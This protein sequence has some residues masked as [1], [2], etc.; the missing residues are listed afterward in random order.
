MAEVSNDG[1]YCEGDTI[2][3]IC[4]NPQSGATYSWSGPGGWTSTA[5]NPVIYPATAA[6]DGNTYSLVKTLNGVSS[7]PASTTIEVIPVNTS[8]NV[9]PA[10]ATIC[11]GSS[12]TLMGSR[13]S[14]Y[15]NTYSWSPGGLS[16]QQ[17]TV[18]PTTTTTYS[19]T[20]TV[21][22][23][24]TGHDTVTVNVRQPQHQSYTLDTC[25]SSYSWHGH[26]ANHE[27][28]FNWTWSHQDEYGCTQ[29]D[30]L[31]LTLS[32]SSF[33][34]PTDVHDSV[35]CYSNIQTPTPP[36]IEVCGNPVP[37]QL[38]STLNGINGGCGYFAYVYQY[39]VAGTPYTWTY[40]YHLN[41]SE[42]SVPSNRDTL[43]QCL[44]D[45]VAPMP[46]VVVNA[47]GDTIVPESPTVSNQTN[48]C[49]GYLSY[50]WLY[51]DCD[52]HRKT[53]T[54]TYVVADT[55][56]PVFIVPADTFVCRTLEGA[57]D[58]NPNITG[59]PWQ[60]MDNCSSLQ[61]MTIVCQDSLHSSIGRG[62]DTLLRTWVVADSCDNARTQT[63]RILIYPPDSAYTGNY[64]CEGE[65]FDAYG[66]NFVA[67]HD[68]VVY[69]HLQSVHTGCDSVTE[70]FLTVWHP[71]PV[72]E[73]VE[74]CD[75]YTWH[76]SIYTT[77][78]IKT[79][80]H[81]DAN[82][83]KQVDT[84]HLTIRHN[85]HSTL[86]SAICAVDFPFQWNGATFHIPGGMDSITIPN[87]MG[88]D[89]LITM[90]VTMKPNT[91]SVLYDT[92]VQNALPYDTLN[93][94]FAAAGSMQTTISNV[95]G[96][97][98]VVTMI[99]TVLP[100]ILIDLDSTVCE[101]DLP[102]QWNGLD[103][104]QEGTQN[105]TLIASSTVDST[106]SMHLHVNPNT[107]ST[108]LDT[109]IENNLSHTFNGVVFA[110]SVT[111][112]RVVI[113][114]ANGCDSIITY[115]LFVW[116]NVK[117]TAD[118]W[119]C[120]NNNWPLEWNG[121]SF[122]GEG[123]ASVVLT[124]V[125]GEDS[126]LLMRVHVNPT[127]TT[128]LQQEI[129][130][131]DLPYRYING[132]IDT[133]FEVG[134]PPLVI[135]PYILSTGNG[136]D[137]VVTLRLDVTDTALSIVSTDDFCVDDRA[138]LTVRSD[139]PDYEWSTGETTPSIVVSEPGIYSVTASRGGCQGRAFVRIRPCSL[140]LR[141]PNAITPG[142]R[143]GLNDCF[144]LPEAMLDQI[145]ECEI[146]IFNRWGNVVFHSNDKRFKWYGDYQ[147]RVLKDEVLVFTM[148]YIDDSRI[149]H[150]FKGSVVVL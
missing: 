98:S 95:Y 75:S 15:T 49:T 59:T 77:G 14:G 142:S 8:I 26:N 94:H 35:P 65:V 61:D 137:S 116:R 103:F 93:M 115:S 4:N 131:N 22:G 72:S 114:N 25:A 106:L 76:D 134:T 111:N 36:T 138:T 20:Q 109:V 123:E 38:S 88:C 148:K 107:Y 83:C 43:V 112:V 128:S 33:T 150:R 46:P 9:S 44:A 2:H 40:Y 119:V 100:N 13:V 57:F 80:E 136:C 27:G 5:V 3:L 31:H 140:E 133:T 102:V 89:S 52:H 55:T 110:D 143:D 18:T 92:I 6:M 145:E 39:T 87:A 68:T 29:V 63:Q 129:C 74:Y 30:T 34:P 60:V 127:K 117:D 71:M 54:C 132:Q 53:W 56:R 7:A 121:V 130:M 45:A 149:M 50:S 146:T 82:G 90:R 139:L 19:M 144:S 73:T 113:S 1:P 124:G 51:K 96:C 69:Q 66:F 11:R 10:T 70:V 64:I 24:C 141:L 135:V 41:P 78:G 91:S 28:T 48:G 12:A 67:D 23:R 37:V 84:L 21:A 17:I 99:L 105:L 86:D 118:I 85:T 32:S 42:F 104:V 101:N 108:V 126:T 79:Y 97:D 62:V 47:C 125:H 120:D 81:L 147:G 122:N 58:A 16:G